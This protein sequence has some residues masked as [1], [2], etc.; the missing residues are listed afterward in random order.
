MRISHETI[1]LSLYVGCWVVTCGVVCAPAGRC[2]TREAS[3]S[4]RV[5]ASSSD[6]IAIRQRTAEV[7]GRAPGTLGGRPDA[8]QT[9]SAV[10]TS[11]SGPA[12]RS[13]WS[14]CRLVGGP[15]R[16][17]RR[18]PR[19]WIGSQAA[20]SVV[21]LGLRQRNGRARPV[22][23]RHRD[24]G[25]FLRP[26]SPWQRASNENANGLVHQSLPRTVNLRRFCQA[27][28]DRIAAELNG[29]PRRLQAPHRYSR[30]RC[31]E[32]MRPPPLSGQRSR[33]AGSPL[34]PHALYR[35]A[36]TADDTQKE[37]ALR[38]R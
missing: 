26:R 23:G 19:Q 8:R 36:Q 38:E 4:R 27:D 14:P 29:R 25:V 30:R 35:S 34:A 31:A 3:A 18:W 33:R 13:C 37:Q 9:P 11:S 12:D 7:D 16:S 17:G 1:Y 32:P 10:V 21:D 24:P 22:H 6:T 15:S 2:A 5:G 28:L 20:A